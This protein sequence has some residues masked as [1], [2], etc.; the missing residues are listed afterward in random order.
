MSVSGELTELKRLLVLGG[1]TLDLGGLRLEIASERAGGTVTFKNGT[2]TNGSLEVAVPNGDI[3]FES[4]NIASSVVYELEAASETIRF[5]NASVS[6]KCTIRSDT[7][8][9]VEYSSVSDITLAGNGSLVAGQGAELGSVT[10]GEGASG[11]KVTVTPDASV[12]SVQLK[13]AADVSVTAAVPSLSA[14]T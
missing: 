8:V 2:I 4:A 11:A 3:S 12:S 5:S 9:Q 13:A 6:G 14:G 1:H 7:R 10:V